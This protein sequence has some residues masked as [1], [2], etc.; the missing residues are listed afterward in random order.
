MARKTLTDLNDPISV[1]KRQYEAA[2]AKLEELDA[3][4]DKMMSDKTSDGLKKGVTME[5][6]DEALRNSRRQMMAM[7]GALDKW[8]YLVKHKDDP[9]TDPKVPTGDVSAVIS[10]SLS[11]K[12]EDMEFSVNY[13]LLASKLAN[14]IKMDVEEAGASDI[15]LCSDC[16]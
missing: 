12:M 2:V 1:A 13:G 5:S 16:A 9:S 11:D 6:F 3:I 10:V 14:T 8:Q 15:P 4:S 7:F